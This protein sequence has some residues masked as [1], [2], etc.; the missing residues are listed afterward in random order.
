MEIDQD[1]CFM[2]M[3]GKMEN[4]TLIDLIIDIQIDST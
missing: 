2:E 4:I 3:L 1:T